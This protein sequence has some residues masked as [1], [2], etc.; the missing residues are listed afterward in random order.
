[1]L[2]VPVARAVP[3]GE[4]L[5]VWGAGAGGA[6]G[7]GGPVGARDV[8]SG[9]DGETGGGLGPEGSRAEQT[10]T[11]GTSKPG[12]HTGDGRALAGEVTVLSL[13]APAP[14]ASC[15]LWLLSAVTIAPRALDAHKGVAGRVLSVGGPEGMSGDGWLCAPGALRMGAGLV[16]CFLYTFIADLDTGVFSSGWSHSTHTTHYSG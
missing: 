2:L 8:P 11:F 16:P 4:G 10:F 9:L 12:L 3:H 15:A 7:G 14:I 6:G 13:G 1:M 5:P